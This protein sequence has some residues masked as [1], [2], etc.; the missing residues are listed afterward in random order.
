MPKIA[1]TIR[2]VFNSHTR[3]K[4]VPRVYFARNHVMLA[5]NT[6][7]GRAALD[8]SFKAPHP[9]F[10]SPVVSFLGALFL[11]SLGFPLTFLNSHRLRLYARIR[12]LHPLFTASSARVHPH[13]LT[14]ESGVSSLRYIT[15]GHSSSIRDI[16]FCIFSTSPLPRAS[17]LLDNSY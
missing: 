14:H 5:T 9:L 6:E 13:S 4:T 12:L 3:P 2:S 10:F 11:R 7:N 16:E 8:C 17:L 15:E 1:L